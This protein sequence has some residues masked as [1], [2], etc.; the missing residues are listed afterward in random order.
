VGFPYF[1]AGLQPVELLHEL[2]RLGLVLRRVLEAP[3]RRAEA[4]VHLV[5]DAAEVGDDT[6]EQPDDE[7]VARRPSS[8]VEVEV[9]EQCVVRGQ[10]V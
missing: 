6:V 4:L 9:L 5:E 2:E 3:E 8:P 1:S 10:G 7:A